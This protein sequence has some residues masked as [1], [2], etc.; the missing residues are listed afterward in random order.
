MG[1]ISSYESG[2]EFLTVSRSPVEVR[3]VHQREILTGRCLKETA[4]SMPAATC[5]G[6][7]VVGDLNG[8]GLGTVVTRVYHGCGEMLDDRRLYC[9]ST[10]SRSVETH[11]R[12]QLKCYPI[13]RV[14]GENRVT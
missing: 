5:I 13:Q 8:T 10:A 14:G 11:P 7:Q 3:P 6:P 9:D 1:I 12:N 4:L 2:R